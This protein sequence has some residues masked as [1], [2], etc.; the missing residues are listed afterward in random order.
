MGK[1]SFIEK[2]KTLETL[3]IKV[4]AEVDIRIHG[5]VP[6]MSDLRRLSS[7]AVDFSSRSRRHLR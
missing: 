6:V 3:S 4:V 5:V 7:Q 1:L 2:Q